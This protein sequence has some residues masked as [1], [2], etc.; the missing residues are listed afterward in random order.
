MRS[1]HIGVLVLAAGSI[2]GTVQADTFQGDTNL[3]FS[4]PT[5]P[6]GPAGP[7]VPF[8]TITNAAGFGPGAVSSF[9]SGNGSPPNS[10]TTT[11]TNFDVNAEVNFTVATLV[12]YNGATQI[13]TSAT[14]VVGTATLHFTTP[15]DVNGNEESFDFNFA[16]TLTPN[17]SDPVAS[18]DILDISAAGAPHV[19]TS[20]G[21]Q[22]TLSILG[23]RDVNGVLR[24]QFILP[25]N[26]TATADLIG[27]ITTNIVPLP[28]AGAMGLATMAIFGMRRRVRR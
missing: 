24:N 8:T 15:P 10:L 26:Q 3:T 18:S 14:G 5:G 20:G 16:L 19:F 9:V 28:T 27:V 7:W 1:F 22:Y 17:T 11:G 2:V 21:I 25:E 4:G 12:Y 13:D 6:G 23:F